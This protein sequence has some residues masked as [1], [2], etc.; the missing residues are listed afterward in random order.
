MFGRGL[1]KDMPLAV[2]IAFVIEGQDYLRLIEE[3]ED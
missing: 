3:L 2:L 1:S